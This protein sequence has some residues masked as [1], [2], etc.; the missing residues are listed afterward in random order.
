VSETTGESGVTVTPEIEGV[1]FPTVTL[2]ALESVSPSESVAVAVQVIESVFEAV[3]L[4]SVTLDPDPIVLEP[5]VQAYVMVGEPPSSSVAVAEQVRV[6]ETVTPLDGETATEVTAGA[7]LST[8]TLSVPESVPPSES[9]AVASQ[10][11]VS[12]GD[13]VELVRV[14]LELVPR[15]LEPFVHS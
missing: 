15:V 8:L 1:L 6:D 14:R 9:V 3:E 10:V 4:L 13:A 5:F 12:E 11:M 7:V 2:S